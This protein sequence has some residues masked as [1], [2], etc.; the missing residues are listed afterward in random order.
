MIFSHAFNPRFLA[1][2]TQLC[3]VSTLSWRS[4]SAPCTRCGWLT[5]TSTGPSRGSTNTSRSSI[6]IFT[7]TGWCFS[8]FHWQ[9]P[10][11]SLCVQINPSHLRAVKSNPSI[12]W[13]EPVFFYLFIFLNIQIFA[14][15][16]CKRQ[17]AAESHVR[18]NAQPAWDRT[19]KENLQQNGNKQTDQTRM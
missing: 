9:G 15:K 11:A 6:E 14:Q 19:N 16:V 8:C 12:H 18:G 5:A 2:L 4:T 7:S 13:Q 3:M 10:C 1:W 17:T